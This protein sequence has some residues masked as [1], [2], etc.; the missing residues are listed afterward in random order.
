MQNF[1]FTVTTDLKIRKDVYGQ[2]CTD[3]VTKL[4]VKDAIDG[5]KLRRV[6]RLILE[7]T[8][9][10]K[11]GLYGH[12]RLYKL[13]RLLDDEAVTIRCTPKRDRHLAISWE[14][15]NKKEEISHLFL[16]H[17]N[18]INHLILDAPTSN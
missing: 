8:V 3:A 13:K 1:K 17:E 6:A 9:E 15:E 2:T 14:S 11:D 5:L 12:T 4:H 18:G 10:V 7:R 16:P